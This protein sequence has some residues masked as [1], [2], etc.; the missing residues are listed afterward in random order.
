V[1]GWSAPRRLRELLPDDVG[2][3]RLE[4]AER[5]V[6]GHHPRVPDRTDGRASVLVAVVALL[7]VVLFVLVGLLG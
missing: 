7:I 1:S 5:A 4:V 2:P 3:P 6:E